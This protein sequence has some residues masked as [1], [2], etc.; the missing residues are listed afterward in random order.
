MHTINILV[1]LYHFIVFVLFYLSVC[2][3]PAFGYNM[4]YTLIDWMID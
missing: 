1:P 3:N 4:K 2:V